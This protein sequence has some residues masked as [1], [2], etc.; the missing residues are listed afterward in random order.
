MTDKSRRVPRNPGF[1]PPV[2]DDCIR[3]ESLPSLPCPPENG[4]HTDTFTLTIR[5]GDIVLICGSSEI[6]VT[7]P[8]CVNVDGVN[9]SARYDSVSPAKYGILASAHVTTANGSRVT[10]EDRF[11]LPREESCTVNLRRCV[12]VDSAADGDSGIASSFTLSLPSADAEWFVPGRVFREFLR[13]DSHE[14]TRIEP[15]LGLPFAMLRDRTT[16]VTLS[17][18][19]YQPVI[20]WEKNS[21]A[22]VTIDNSANSVTVDYPSR[23]PEPL[24]RPMTPGS[25]T[26]YDLSV[27]LSVTESYDTAIAEVYGAHFDL[28]NQRIL[29]TDIDEVFR[30]I[31]E[32]YKAFLHA[33]P[34]TRPDGSTYTSY[35]LPW[36][37]SIED[38][39][40]GPL[41]YQAGFVGQQMMAAHEMILY[42]VRNHDALSLENGVKTL[43]FWVNDAEWMCGSGIPKI[44]YDTWDNGFRKYPTFLRM[45]VDGIEGLLDAYLTAKSAGIDKPDWYRDVLAFAEFLVRRQNADGSWYR[46]FDYE[47]NPYVDPA[48]GIHKPGNREDICDSFSK[49][50][51]TMPVRFLKSVFD[52]TGDVRCR[53]A[54]VRAGEFVYRELYP[55]SSWKGGTCDNPNVTDKEAGVYAM[56]CFDAMYLLTGD[57]KYLTALESA[58]AFTMSSVYTVSVP[59]KDT[60]LKAG[61]PMKAGYIDGMSLITARANG[62]DNYIAFAYA[63]LFRIYVLTGKKTYLR[64]AEFLQQN[65]K[66]IMNWDGA[67]GYKY[68]S[69]VAEASTV[70]TR[71]GPFTYGSV[72][73]GVWLPWCSAAN[74]DPIAKML[75]IFGKADVADLAD[76]PLDELRRLIGKK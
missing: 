10:I 66:A 35:G 75:T 74:A 21:F 76:V 60:T 68:K 69:L 8:V 20:H 67:L 39:A 46:C 9:Y 22:S 48:P 27:R 73:N 29:D 42:G 61:I 55:A 44:W 32:D 45:A 18:G 47:G 13:Q 16:G 70:I 6:P 2:P 49:N 51:T 24:Y 59:V 58:A 63:E 40:F 31:C 28:Q 1:I 34:Q 25:Q 15:A 14:D 56:Y 53:D 54:A 37:I 17:L 43:D 19:R 62:A 65:T 71:D 72:D 23:S 5:D 11:Y 41:T 30:V 64:Q 26:V 3:E 7:C 36:R 12:Q 50:N 52:L 33:T 38:G 4:L 57:E